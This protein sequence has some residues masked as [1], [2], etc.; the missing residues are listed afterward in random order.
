M[1]G[2]ILAS[3]EREARKRG[4]ERNP[5][6]DEARKRDNYRTAQEHGSGPKMQQLCGAVMGWVCVRCE[7]MFG[8]CIRAS[9]LMFLMPLRAHVA[10]TEKSVRTNINPHVRWEA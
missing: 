1:P 7:L 10:P 3:Q 6:C 9:H 4:G 5:G 8:R 2:L